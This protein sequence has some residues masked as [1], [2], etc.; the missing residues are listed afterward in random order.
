MAWREEAGKQVLQISFLLSKEEYIAF[1]ID[2]SKQECRLGGLLRRLIGVGLF[3]LGPGGVVFRRGTV[4][5]GD[6][7]ILDSAAG[8]I[9]DP[10]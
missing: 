7:S 8:R 3:C 4:Y 6:G 5:A 2:A 9:F 1:S 10:V